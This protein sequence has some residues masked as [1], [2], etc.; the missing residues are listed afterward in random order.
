MEERLHNR[1]IYTGL[2]ILRWK[3]FDARPIRHDTLR[4]VASGSVSFSMCLNVLQEIKLGQLNT[5]NVVIEK[6]SV[7]CDY[8]K[9]NKNKKHDKIFGHNASST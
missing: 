7:L 3:D 4:K 8:L 6:I 9:K 1:I 2:K 5:E